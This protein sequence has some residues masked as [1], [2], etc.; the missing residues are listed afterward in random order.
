MLKRVI[1]V[2]LL[3]TGMGLNINPALSAQEPAGRAGIDRELTKAEE[4]MVV[5]YNMAL[6]GD[7][8]SAIINYTRALQAEPS[9]CA[10]GISDAGLKAARA[11][12]YRGYDFL[13]VF[14]QEQ[15]SIPDDCF[16]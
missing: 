11:A 9:P 16:V 14:T 1:A 5:A 6:K 3:L 2:G 12:K 7:Y 8:D 4:Y 15:Q 13:E 10:M